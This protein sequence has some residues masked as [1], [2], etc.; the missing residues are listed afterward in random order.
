MARRATPI[1]KTSTKKTFSKETVADM[2]R[3]AKAPEPWAHPETLENLVSLLAAAAGM[4]IGMPDPTGH[5][6]RVRRARK[7]VDELRRV[8]PGLVWYHLANSS[9]PSHLAQLTPEKTDKLHT[10]HARSLTAMWSA[11]VDVE[12]EV[13]SKKL[14]KT[15]CGWHMAAAGLF[16]SYVAL[17]G[18]GTH[19]RRG[20]AARFVCIALKAAGYGEQ[21]LGAIEA[22]LDSHR[23][24]SREVSPEPVSLSE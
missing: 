10:E 21:E 18:S 22:A 7:A 17:V 24:T 9:E 1:G 23:L 16:L 11:L 5:I 12:G 14:E 13:S 4:S 3:A 19:S 15:L 20:P 6:G 2:V 8:L